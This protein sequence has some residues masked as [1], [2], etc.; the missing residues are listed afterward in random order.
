ME[1]TGD[2][3]VNANDS[4]YAAGERTVQIGF[5]HELDNAWDYYQHGYFSAALELIDHQLC[6]KQQSEWVIYPILFLC[7]HYIDVDSSGHRNVADAI[8]RNCAGPLEGAREASR[9]R[10]R[11]PIESQRVGSGQIGSATG[12]AGDVCANAGAASRQ[13]KD[14]R[15]AMRALLTFPSSSRLRTITSRVP[16][17]RAYLPLLD[18]P[19]SPLAGHKPRVRCR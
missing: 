4:S 14:N 9:G 17:P 2:V 19:P 1:Y 12:P 8:E 15:T 13:E 3:Q 18:W 7:R 16:L 10:D 5:E 11:P 6:E